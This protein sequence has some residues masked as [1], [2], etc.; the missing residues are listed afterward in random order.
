[1]VT[2]WLKLKDSE[3]GRMDLSQAIRSVTPENKHAETR[4]QDWPAMESYVTTW[5]PHCE[6]LLNSRRP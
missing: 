2:I 1:M 6:D 3:E 4:L 5:F